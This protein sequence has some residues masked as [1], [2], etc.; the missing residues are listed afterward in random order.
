M[1]WVDDIKTRFTLFFFNFYIETLSVSNLMA[2]R[3]KGERSK[4][5]YGNGHEIYCNA[6]HRQNLTHIDYQVKLRNMV[7]PPKCLHMSLET[8]TKLI[9]ESLKASW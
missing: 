5:M 7:P 8:V 6:V 1:T 3:P 2:C 9:D 4:F